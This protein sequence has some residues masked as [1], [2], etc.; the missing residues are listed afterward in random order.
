M[1]RTNSKRIFLSALVALIVILLLG[2]YVLLIAAVVGVIGLPIYC[3]VNSIKDRRNKRKYT[4]IKS[5]R[6]SKGRFGKLR[7]SKKSM[8]STMQRDPISIKNC[9]Y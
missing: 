9:K 6:K 1:M 5:E 8:Y 2:Q 3:L 7:K 4:V